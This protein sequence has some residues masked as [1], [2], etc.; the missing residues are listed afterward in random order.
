MDTEEQEEILEDEEDTWLD[1]KLV[2]KPAED[3]AFDI[4]A[5]ANLHAPIVTKALSDQYEESPSN[6]PGST[7][8]DATEED[9]AELE[10][11]DTDW[12]SFW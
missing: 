2:S 1:E 3:S 10:G 7:Q 9:D 4:E 6:D 11:M 5:D 8:G 12:D